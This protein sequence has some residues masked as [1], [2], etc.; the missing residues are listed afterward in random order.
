MR[1]K[2]LAL[3]L[4][5]IGT[6]AILGS[7]TGC[8]Q[9]TGGGGGGGA[10]GPLGQL[11]AN[12]LVRVNTWLVYPGDSTPSGPASSDYLILSTDGSIGQLSRNDAGDR[13]LVP[14][15]NCPNGNAILSTGNNTYYFFDAQKKEIRFL[16]WTNAGVGNVLFNEKRELIGIT[17]GGGAGSNGLLVA[18]CNGQ[19]VVNNNC[20]AASN[21][22]IN[23]NMVWNTVVATNAGTGTVYSIKYPSDLK[24]AFVVDGSN[25]QESVSVKAG[26]QMGIGSG[27]PNWA[28]LLELDNNN[29]VVA[30]LLVNAQT[31][32]VYRKELPNQPVDVTPNSNNAPNVFLM[33]EDGNNLYIA[34]ARIGENDARIWYGKFDGNNL[35]QISLVDPLA[36]ANNEQLLDVNMDGKG[37]LY[38][39]E[40]QN[41]NTIKS[42]TTAGNAAS[43]NAGVGNNFGA[44][45]PAGVG[46]MI[47]PLED[48]VV[49][50]YGGGPTYTTYKAG[51][52]SLT[53][54]QAN[55]D[56]EKAAKNCDNGNILQSG[57]LTTTC[58]NRGAGQN[59]VSYLP[60]ANTA[61]WK[62]VNPDG[63]NT[64]NALNA[65][66]NIY[67]GSTLYL[68]DNQYWYKC[69][70]NQTSCSK[71]SNVTV[72][73]MNNY[74]AFPQVTTG[75]TV[76]YISVVDLIGDS[77]T[78]FNW[79]YPGVNWILSGDGKKAAFT[80]A[81]PTS[82]CDQV[83]NGNV[84][85]TEDITK[86]QNDPNAQTYTS[87]TV[88]EDTT[89]TD[90]ANTNPAAFQ[91]I[92]SVLN[93]WT[94]D[95]FPSNQQ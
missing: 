15:A 34:I 10:G 58:F 69:P 1:K 59:E 38:Y 71:L 83:G 17:S 62:N 53:N 68:R 29:R 88:F 28:G 11:F 22:N 16:A 8:N 4:A 64:N 55:S 78:T 48:G 60:D 51:G 41:Q 23:Q 32:A 90:P 50:A 95:Q 86:K 27:S 26:N 84:I 43:A 63:I 36:N 5:G 65:A 37:N 73:E 74:N 66:A 77:V 56:P 75:A 92:N 46:N 9:L 79:S 7:S 30:L 85:V 2:A 80:Y 67:Q 54:L 19:F 89:L 12:V 52:N 13:N 87:A 70:V 47:L 6:A 81:E 94:E 42:V 93:V 33:R 25:L 44:V 3:A 31:G 61:N 49:L 39:I 76:G 40:N 18:Y 82:R 45:W 72:A 91:C 14:V 57:D 21:C 35:T 24:G 20:S